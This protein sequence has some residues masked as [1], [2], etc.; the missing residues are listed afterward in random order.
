MCVCVF[1]CVFECVCVCLYVCVCVC[2]CVGKF[3]KM[4]ATP[5]FLIPDKGKFHLIRSAGF[6]NS[7]IIKDFQI[8]LCL[9]LKK[10]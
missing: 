4:S 1:E 10:I 2:V 9:I 8:E 6:S 3:C 7:A 5:Y